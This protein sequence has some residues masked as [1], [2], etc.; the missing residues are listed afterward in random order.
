MS[1]QDVAERL[2]TSWGRSITLARGTTT[3]PANALAPWDGMASSTT[4]QA[5]KG[6]FLDP[7]NSESNFDYALKI[8]PRTTITRIDWHIVIASK[9]LTFVPLPGDRVTD[10]T[11]YYQVI[12]VSPAHPGDDT[13]LY[14]LQVQK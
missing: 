5:I 13:Y 14:I 10:G 8:V 6:V 2:V 11:D 7:R 3:T 1:L 12:T 9:G 4:S